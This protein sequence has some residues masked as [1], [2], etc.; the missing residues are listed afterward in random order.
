[1]FEF[2]IFVVPCTIFLMKSTE[3]IVTEILIYDV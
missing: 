3:K 1:M 2:V